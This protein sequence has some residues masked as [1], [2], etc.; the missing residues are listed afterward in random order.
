MFKKVI[1][2]LFFIILFTGKGFGGE[3]L[4]ATE[5][6]SCFYA[7]GKMKC[8]KGQF[9]ITYYQEGDKIVRTNVFNKKKKESISDNT[10]Y[11]VIGDLKS[12]PRHND[13]K[14]LPQVVRAIG[15]PG[16]DAVEMLSIGADYIQAVKSTSDYFVINRY[17]ITLE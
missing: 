12:D 2:L 7:D 17:K 10:V 5:I 6:E 13:G 3:V 9:R 15:F 8:S 14:F 11:S 4:V 1:F 16:T